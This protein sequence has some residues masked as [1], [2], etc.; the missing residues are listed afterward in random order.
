MPILNA[1]FLVSIVG[2]VLLSSLLL[3]SSST[4]ST[5]TSTSTSHPPLPPSLSL[6]SLASSVTDVIDIA[7]LAFALTDLQRI[8]IDDT[9]LVNALGTSVVDNV[10]VNQQVNISSTMT[11]NQDVTQEFVYIVQIKDEQ[12]IVVSISWIGGE[13]APAKTFTSSL[14]W[15]ADKLGQ[16]TIDIF[17]W[18]DLVNH[19]ALSE[20]I[21]LQI[22][23]S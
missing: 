7:P 9:N 19:N 15:T 14:S 18:E 12:G 21:T 16:Y 20:K 2:L 13:S 17:V 22:N 23:V 8:T 4:S 5:S 11:N 3:L 1:S 6:P 10:N